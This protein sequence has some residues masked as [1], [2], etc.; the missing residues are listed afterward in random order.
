MA[1]QQE[2]FLN[3]IVQNGVKYIAAGASPISLKRGIDL[4]VEAI[5]KELSKQAIEI[6]DFQEIK[7]I[8]TVSASGNE[9][10]GELIAQ[11]ITKVGKQG[12]VTIEE[13][14]ST[15]TVIEM[16]EGMQFD[17]GY[18][19]AYFAT[20][21]DKMSVEMEN[22]A[23]LVVDKKISSI[24]EL[25]PIL[26]AVATT[27][28]ELLIIADDIE[29]DALATLVVNKIRGTLKV[30]AVKAP[31]FGDRKR[32]MLE[33]LAILTGATFISDEMG[34]YLKDATMSSVG[35]ADRVIVTKD[36]TTIV[37]GKGDH[38][39]ITGRVKLLEKVAETTTSSYDKE[40][41]LERKGKLSGGIAVIRVGAAT[42]PELKQKKQMFEDS[43]SSTKA[44]LEE[45]IVVG[46]GIALL[47]ASQ[48]VSSLK[49]EGDY[50]VGA[51]LVVKAAETPVRQI[52]ANAGLDGSVILWESV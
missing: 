9:E 20:N 23:I 37:G 15:D 40:K 41:M 50:L 49:L 35:S 13:A 1:Q 27:G 17:R 42:E 10:I 21:T 5:V 22:P 34:I 30:V 28:K 47:S 51:E 14:K 8:A 11:A 52:I 7:N 39:L 4:A 29:A 26:Q 19:S 44:A 46:G 16:V 31:G 2:L 33:D 36:T 6:K 32:A 12:V 3:A 25:I 48:V 45:G 43:L 24:Q 18:M 38:K